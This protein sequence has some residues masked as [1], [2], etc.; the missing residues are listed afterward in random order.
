MDLH[1]TN[2]PKSPKKLSSPACG[3][4]LSPS[5]QSQVLIGA[6][7]PPTPT[8]SPSPQATPPTRTEGSLVA[9]CPLTLPFSH[10]GDAGNAHFWVSSA[11]TTMPSLNTPHAQLGTPA[12]HSL[13]FLPGSPPHTMALSPPDTPPSPARS[14]PGPRPQQEVKVPR[15]SWCPSLFPGQF[16]PLLASP[17]PPPAQP[18]FW[19]HQRQSERCLAVQ[20]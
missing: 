17:G 1:S 8:Q 9:R 16:S 2:I 4:S 11:N 10:V 3:S 12:P 5:G 6:L 13:C 15:R 19:W 7:S 14:A 18:G 20:A